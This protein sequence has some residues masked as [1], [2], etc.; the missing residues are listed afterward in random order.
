[1]FVTQ[2][3]EQ[4]R[5]M[6]M[7][8]QRHE[9]KRLDLHKCPAGKWTIGY[10]HNLEAN[11]IPEHIANDLLQWDL[12]QAEIAVKKHLHVER[13]NKPR[14]AVLINM[15]FNLGISGLLQFKNF[16]YYLSMDNYERAADEM[17]DSRWAM[18]VGGRAKE[19]AEQMRTGEW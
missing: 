9:G 18:Q 7:Q 10:G 8:V 15:A 17:L 12:I 1:M 4:Y 14:L 11:G 5:K 13:L 3:I 19:L 16:I 2:D 6:F